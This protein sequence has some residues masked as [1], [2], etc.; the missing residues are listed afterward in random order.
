MI[1]WHK[2]GLRVADIARKTG[3]D[4]QF[5]TRWISKL[6]NGEAIEDTKRS[7]RPRKRTADV[8]RQIEKEIK[9]KR[10]RSSRVV[11]R[12]LK[13]R[14]VADLSYTTVQRAA[15]DRGLRPYRCTKTS[16]LTSR[17][18]HKEQRLK[19]A[20]A[21]KRKDWSMV[22]FSDEHQFKQFKGGNLVHDQVWEKS[23]EEVPDKEVERWGLSMDVWAGI[24]VRGKTK[25]C[26]YEGG[27]NAQ[28]YQQILK[29]ALVPAAR[30]W[31]KD[32]QSGW[33]LQQDKAT[34][35][36]AKSTMRFLEQED[37]TVV[38]GWPPKGDDINPIENLWAILDERLEGKK[39]KTKNGMKKALLEIW[40]QVDEQL[41][42]NLV[43][44][45]PNRLRRI[46]KAKGGSIK[47]VR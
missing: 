15:H 9:G 32:N 47:R 18:R 23:H 24:S 39:F 1:A 16:R 25:L 38:E 46:I 27:L 12:D 5:I 21:N 42:H 35:H 10:R 28:S 43:D 29:K 6:E 45:V 22:V 7:G 40:K 14:K 2:E 26:F 11:A 31:F 37:V 30:G 33:Q 19:F 41:L 44:S 36:T 13:R 20:K 17:Q 4:R 34:A 3:F 8:E